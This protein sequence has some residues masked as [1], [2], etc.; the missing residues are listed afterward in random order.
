MLLL[1]AVA[2]PVWAHDVITTKI[3]WAREISRLF[4]RHCMSCHQAGGKAPFAL[5]TWEEARPWAVAIREEVTMRRMPPW[6]A[7]KGFGDF[8]DDPS[9]TQEQIQMIADWVNGG[10]PEGDK[11]LLSDKPPK[12]WTGAT[13]P[14]ARVLSR[15]HSLL[16][17]TR[18]EVVGLAVSALPK[19]ADAVVTLQR[20]DQSV[21]PLLWL[22]DYD[23][24]FPQTYV[25]RAPIAAQAGSRIRVASKSPVK[26]QVLVSP[27]GTKRP[28]PSARVPSPHPARVGE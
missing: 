9:L 18:T 4:E 20:P 2:M 13:A 17:A 5:T 10:A 21:E 6:S 27:R 12:A 7:V 28:A 22:K 26:L 19:G 8:R 15:T 24:S 16:L 11:Q 14:A 3:T 23:P 25:F 1:T